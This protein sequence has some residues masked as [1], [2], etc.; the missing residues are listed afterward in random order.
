MSAENIVTY[1]KN[2]K[3]QTDWKRVRA[4]TEEEIVA[5]ANSDPDAPLTPP[6]QLKNFKR[7]HPAE[8][9]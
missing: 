9:S 2:M 5:A 7:V 1:N 6:E 3:G 4:L 8:K